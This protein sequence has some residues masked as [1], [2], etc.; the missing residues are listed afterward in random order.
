MHNKT[1]VMV[2]VATGSAVCWWPSI[3]EPSLDLAWWIP[4]LCIALCATFAT[5]LGERRL[6]LLTEA[7]IIG[8]LAGL[9]VG[10]A[11]WPPRDPIARPWA[12]YYV[13]VMTIRTAVVS[14]GFGW[15]ARFL[16]VAGETR[17]IIW[18]ALLSVVAFGPIALAL[19]PPLVSHRI[20]ENE[21]IAAERFAALSS[22]VQRTAG[23]DGDL[24]RICEG[25]ALRQHYAGPSFR[26]EDWRRITGNYVKQN[27]YMF[28]VYCHEKGGYTIAAQPARMGADGRRR[29]CAD[30]SGS[31]GCGIGWNRS[32]NACVPCPK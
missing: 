26:D 13:L 19:T 14:S 1:F 25:S 5:L 6:L 16:S 10:V 11:I 31:P 23:E 29:F 17:I 27:G 20:R 22:A 12:P 30:E 4:L 15:A 8:T 2:L 9:C 32:R 3:I 24:R 28:M 7:S 21:R 18:I